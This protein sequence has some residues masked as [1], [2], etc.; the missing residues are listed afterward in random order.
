MHSRKNEP[1]RA[2]HPPY[3]GSASRD[4]DNAARQTRLSIRAAVHEK[5]HGYASTY[6]EYPPECLLVYF[7][8]DVHLQRIAI[9]STLLLATDSLLPTFSQREGLSSG[10]PGFSGTFSNFFES[11][12]SAACTLRVRSCR[13]LKSMQEKVFLTLTRAT[14]VTMRCPALNTRFIIANGRSTSARVLLMAL[15]RRF[16]LIDKG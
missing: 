16:S 2:H 13:R 5:S 7:R 11:Y 14:V 4:R 9:N 10:T 8:M 6:L 12:R 1:M 3:R 15:F